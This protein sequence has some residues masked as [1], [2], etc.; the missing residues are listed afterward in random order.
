MA[1]NILL[2][3]VSGYLGGTLLAR[4]QN[5][6]L[7]PF[8]NMYAMVRTQE[9]AEKVTQYN[10][11]PLT[12]DVKDNASMTKAI[13][14]NEITIVFF[15]IDAMHSETQVVLIKAL[16]QVRETTGQDVH[17]LHTTGA[18][19]FSSHA[20]HPTDKALLDTD[21]RL[22]ELQKRSKAPHIEL[23]NEVCYQSSI[24]ALYEKWESLITPA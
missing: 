20:G 6:K 3:G 17:F 13:V 16:A 23:L 12:L 9:Q 21:P 8:Q 1:R 22:Y 14:E 11:I 10:V 15:L 19:I 2:T 5:A 4:L 18:K 24:K 7:P